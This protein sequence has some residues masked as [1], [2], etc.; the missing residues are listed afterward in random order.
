MT[1][2]ILIFMLFVIPIQF[3]VGQCGNQIGSAFWPLCL[4]EYGITSKKE[5]L[6]NSGKNQKNLDH[7]QAFHSFFSIPENASNLN[8]SSISDLEAAKIKARVRME[9]F[10][11]IFV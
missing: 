7:L 4:Q 5:K 1:E 6:I 2:Y 10:Q 11:V 9:Q 8:F 3:T